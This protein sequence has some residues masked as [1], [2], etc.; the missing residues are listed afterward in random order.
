MALRGLFTLAL[1]CGAGRAVQPSAPSPLPAPLRHLPWGN[2]N[3]LHS[4]DTHG[5]HAG[6][7]QEPFYSA[8]WGDYISFAERL[9]QK[10]EDDGV[11][12]I[13][14]DTGDRVE[15]NGLYDASDPQGKYTSEVFRQQE[16]DVIC[17]GNHELYKKHTAEREYLTTVPNYGDRYLASNIDI[18]DPE[19]GAR[20]PLARRYRKWTTRNQGVR[21]LAVGFLFDFTGNYNNTFVQ[22]V[23]ETVKETWFRH[24]VADPDLDLILVVGHV[25]IRMKEYTT[26]YR[27]IRRL[28]GPRV[29]IQFFGGHTH[30]RDFKV[31]DSRSTALESGRYME[32]VGFLSMTFPEKG[33]IVFDRRY[34][35]SNLLSYSHHT[36]LTP[37]TFP[38]ARGANVSSYIAEARSALDLDSLY[39]CAP[40]DYWLNRVP[41]PGNGSIISWL[42]EEVL[43]DAVHDEDRK[44]VP[45]LIITN[46]GAMRFD[47]LKGP[48]TK[49]TMFIVSPF[50]NELRYIKD[51]PREKAM[52]ILPLI[53]HGGHFLDLEV[54]VL[55]PPQQLAQ[56]GDMLEDGLPGAQAPL[57]SSIHPD[58]TPLGASSPHADK[59]RGLY[60]GYTTHD[61]ASREKPGDDTL[62]SPLPFHRVPNVFQ[63]AL[64]SPPASSPS[65]EVPEN[66]DVI[67]NA[68]IEPYIILALAFL[69][70]HVD[71]ERDV[72]VYAAGRSFSDVIAEW[73]RTHWSKAC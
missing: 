19:S 28:A 10:A 71:S 24:A 45:G 48:F 32:T 46:T 65:D 54:D 39:G 6:H 9:R 37:S 4:T 53:N 23:A 56:R 17:S 38:T 51:V 55:A 12:L 61:D 42:E 3:F 50:T 58:Q 47:I 13:L 44:G 64:N 20:V 67:F 66:V 7:L 25:G 73:V 34:I 49:D 22:P 57:Q 52:G 62:H 1:L 72:G 14:I 16:M 2:L 68:F 30:V 69:G 18:I 15:G 36:G 41:Y 63:A 26:L 5:W 11:D 27:A 8:D 29:I 43:P 35:D 70:E 59:W 40:R 33:D 60:P 31:Y 21:T